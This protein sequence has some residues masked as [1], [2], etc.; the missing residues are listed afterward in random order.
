MV[1]TNRV[2]M[3]VGGRGS[4]KTVLGKNLQ[5]RLLSLHPEKY[6]L[7]VDTFDHPR[8]RNGYITIHPGMIKRIAQPGKYRV[9]GSNT[10]DIMTE[11][12]QSA[13][14]ACILFE[15]ASKYVPANVPEEV[16]NFVLDSKQRNLDLFFMFHGFGFVPPAL[17]RLVD[18]IY[19][20]RTNDT[21]DT[22]KSL[23]PCYDE[24]KAAFERV[25]ASNDPYPRESIMF[26]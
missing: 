12:Q 10:F 5:N 23:I 11:I 3:I 7:V 16:R 24:V 21:P 1:R 19:V 6:G 22:R 17:Y 26:V 25:R 20:L 2:I 8:Y 14:N 4:G 9:F 18:G 13:H 15:D